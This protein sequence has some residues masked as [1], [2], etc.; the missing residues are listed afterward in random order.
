MELEDGYQYLLS[1]HGD[2]YIAKNGYKKW[3]LWVI[4][5]PNIHRKLAT[6][7]NPEDAVIFIKLM[8]YKSE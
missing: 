2:M 5:P 7:A 6:F 4:E 1:A 3:A 8:K